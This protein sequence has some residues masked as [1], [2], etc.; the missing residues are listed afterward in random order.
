MG[1]HGD[2]PGPGAVDSGGVYQIWRSVTGQELSPAALQEFASRSAAL[3]LTEADEPEL[4]AA[5][6]RVFG[7]SGKLL[8]A[9]WREE[10]DEP[11]LAGLRAVG[12]EWEGDA[13]SAA[14]T[15]RTEIA[16]LLES[17]LTTRDQPRPVLRRRLGLDGEQGLT[18]AALGA[19]YGVSRERIRQLQ[20]RQLQLAAR[21]G[22]SRRSRRGP[23]LR[24][25][26]RSLA[27]RG[28]QSRGAALDE[29]A[30]LV[31]P[32]AGSDLRL[33]AVAV[34]AG[35]PARDRAGSQTR[36]PLPANSG[37]RP[38]GNRPC[39]PAPASACGGCWPQPG[40]RRSLPPGTV[41]AAASTS[42]PGR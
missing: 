24:E 11:G 33:H 42:T 14:L 41:M 30:G 17:A 1:G 12:G 27:D 10:I 19:E 16:Q 15:L 36:L 18:L 21:K 2:G 25:V 8:L 9:D 35:Y 29:I 20:V 32:E 28:G 5:A 3:H 22:R 26:L 7:V 4:T 31:F 38:A 37:E 23:V 39:R 40:G 34:L 13:E 6:R